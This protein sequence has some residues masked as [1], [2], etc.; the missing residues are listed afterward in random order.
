MSRN[1][2]DYDDPR[3][4]HHDDGQ[5]DRSQSNDSQQLVSLFPSLPTT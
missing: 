2:D 4:D 5:S 3:N 1:D